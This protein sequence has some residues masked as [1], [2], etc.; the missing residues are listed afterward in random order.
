MRPSWARVALFRRVLVNLKSGKAIR[1]VL[2]Q[3]RGGLLELR[4]AEL[5]EGTAPPVR[6]D[7]SVFVERSNIDFA[8]ALGP[9]EG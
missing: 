3:E 8:Q 1:G 5:L 9:A 7:G 6:L 4:D 2:V